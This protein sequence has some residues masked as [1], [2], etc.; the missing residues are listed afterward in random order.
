MHSDFS[1]LS[2]LCVPLCCSVLTEA[3]LKA[4]QKAYSP[5]ENVSALPDISTY[6]HKKVPLPK[7]LFEKSCKQSQSE[8]ARRKKALLVRMEALG[9]MV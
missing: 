6:L 3:K 1:I 5:F 7:S 4:L 8:R 9:G 2:N